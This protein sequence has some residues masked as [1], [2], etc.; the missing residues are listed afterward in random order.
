MGAA[1]TLVTVQEFLKLPEVEGERRELIGGEVVTMSNAKLRHELV[2]SNLI[3]ILMAWLLHNP[4]GRLFVETTFV[5][6]QHNSFIPDISIVLPS[7]LDVNADWIE[8]APEI[9]VEVVSSEPAATLQRKI[10]LYL[11]HGAKSVWVVF[12]GER[13]VNVIDSV[14]H[15]TRFTT[16]Q[17][18]EDTSVLPGFST[19]VS[20]IFEG[21]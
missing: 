17:M 4:I 7:R 5:L 10:D 6:D 8:G 9:A 21:I 12:P 19:P 13:I 20:R 14:G 3:R 16:N 11:T 15:A 2:K 1:T 18:L